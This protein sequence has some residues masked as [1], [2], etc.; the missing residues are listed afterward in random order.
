MKLYFEDT[1]TEKPPLLLIAGLASDEISWTFQKEALSQEF[2]LITFD[3]RGVGRSP[4]PPGPYSVAS[5]AQDVLELLDTLNLTQVHML[6]HSMGGAIA[7][8]IAIEHPQRVDRLLLAC[9]F[10]KIGARN[11]A[12]LESW[13]A[14][15]AASQA[16]PRDIG[17]ALFPWLYTE[18]FLDRPGHLEAAHSALAA[19]PYPL[20]ATSVAAQVAAIRDF[21]SS[22]HLHRIQSHT[23]VLL[24]EGDLLVRPSSGQQLAEAIP[25]AKLE[26]LRGTGHAC[27]LET[28]ELFNRAVLDAL[29]PGMI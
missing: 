9:T 18:E 8:H 27:M 11:L 2:R 10:S 7:Q 19:H 15:I 25:G 26:R 16:Q 12:V 28:P 20:D 4:K 3:N 23:V 24:A 5:M 22:P 29:T 1:S 21:D 17:N 13:A 14:T 6:G